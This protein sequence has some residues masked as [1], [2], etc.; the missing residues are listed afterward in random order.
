VIGAKPATGGGTVE[1]PPPPPPPPDQP[2]PPPPATG[3]T[4]TVKSG[5]TLNNIAQATGVSVANLDKWN[6]IITDINVLEVGWVLRLTDPA[7]QP[8]PP[9][10]ATLL[11]GDKVRVTGGTYNGMTGTVQSINGTTSAEIKFRRNVRSVPIRYL[12]KIV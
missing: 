1:P 2:P 5:D 9:P 10:T 3:S 8:P 7:T 6:D 12:S 11:V 4:Y